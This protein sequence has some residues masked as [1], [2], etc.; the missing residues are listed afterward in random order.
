MSTKNKPTVEEVNNNNIKTQEQVASIQSELSTL[1]SEVQTQFTD[2]KELLSA[3]LNKQK[4]TTTS[5]INVKLEAINS[6]NNKNN[7]EVDQSSLVLTNSSL[8]IST[9]ATAHTRFN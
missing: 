1:T 4:S 7:T 2:I 8:P 9:V 6:N 5:D 3:L